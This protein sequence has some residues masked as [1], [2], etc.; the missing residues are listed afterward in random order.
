MPRRGGCVPC[1]GE[2]SDG[3]G[4]VIVKGMNRTKKNKTKGTEGTNGANKAGT[5]QY[6]QF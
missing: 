1:P 5:I 6:A 2:N 3:V 4:A